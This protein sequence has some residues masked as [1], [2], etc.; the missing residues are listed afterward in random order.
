MELLYTIANQAS[1]A[2]E[3]ARIYA[4]V[5]QKALELRRYFHR[6][7]RALGSSQSPEEVPAVIASLTVEVMG[8]DRCAL[9]SLPEGN[10]VGSPMEIEAAVNFRLASGF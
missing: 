4:D 2:I 10:A 6:V 1:I 8:A 9:Y 7:A 5:R 3:N